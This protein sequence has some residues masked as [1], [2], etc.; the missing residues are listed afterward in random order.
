MKAW[1]LILRNG[2]CQG[3]GA[4]DC[5]GQS[6]PYYGPS[7]VCFCV[8]GAIMHIYGRDAAYVGCIN[9]LH[10]SIPDVAV[11]WNDTPGRT[12]EEVVAKLKELD[13]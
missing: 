11:T 5:D 2:W 7:A 4:R 8:T 10:R 9:K 6:V 13:I 3:A 1:E 12:K